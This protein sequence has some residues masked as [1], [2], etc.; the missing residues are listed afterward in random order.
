MKL[1]Y[2]FPL[3][4]VAASLVCHFFSSLPTHN[5]KVLRKPYT[6]PNFAPQ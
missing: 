6:K 3:T 1:I 4:L 5:I 2:W